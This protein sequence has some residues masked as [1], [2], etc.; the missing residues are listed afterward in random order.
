MNPRFFLAAALCGAVICGVLGVSS[1]PAGAQETPPD[2]TTTATLPEREVSN[3]IDAEIRKVWERDGIKGAGECGD[4]EFVRRVYLDSVGLPPTADEVVAFLGDKDKEKRRKL[5]AKLVDDDRFGEHLGDL[6][7]DIMIGRTGR[8][9]GGSTHL[10]AIWFA[11]QINADRKFSDIIYDLV[12]AEGKLSENPAVGVYTRENPISTAN[13]AGLVTKNL[14]GVQIQCAECHDHPYEEAW[15]EA[16]FNGVASFWSPIQMR[17]NNRVL[18][19]DPEVTDTAR[20]PNFSEDQLERVSAERRKALKAAMRYN[21]PVTLD[22]TAIKTDDRR[23]WRPAMAKWMV[24]DENKQT[25]KYI[26]NRFWSFA[27]GSGILNPIDD[28]NSFNEASHP[29]LLEIL[30]QDLIDNDYD[31]K[32]LYRAILN[33]KTYQ[34]SSSG[35]PAKAELW[36]FA[37]APV[38]Q[39]SPEQFFGTFV[40]IAG[41]DDIARAYRMRSGSPG[42]Q[43]KRRVE[44]RLKRMQNNP[45]DPNQREYGY[46]EE[47]LNRFVG[48]FEKMGATW[49]MRR[50]MAQGYASIGNDD[51]MNEADGFSL[52]IDQALLVMNGEVTN[53]LS[54]SKRGTLIWKLVNEL[55][56]DDVRLERLYLTVLSRRPTADEARTMKA[57]LKDSKDKTAG[58]EDIMFALLATTEFATN[59]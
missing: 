15:T 42:D 3:R 53:N 10:F 52:T 1:A 36:H 55:K 22:G 38:R 2:K 16:T 56:D 33:S 25:A 23:F 19:I 31:I 17:L 18:P 54:G 39:L 7:T 28:F 47:S 57:H 9:Y 27:F 13:A 51:E 37:S 8:N 44:D 32:R 4:E 29:E 50:S 21:K 12:V 11:E 45:D 59:H 24:S 5:I 58:W 26:A 35:G 41:G 14:T 20:S 30:G 34:L 48:W 40:E 6:W 43:L 46:N 49:Y